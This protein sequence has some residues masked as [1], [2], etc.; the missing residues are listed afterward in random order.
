M[1]RALFNY[2][3][4]TNSLLSFLYSNYFQIGNF[5]EFSLFCSQFYLKIYEILNKYQK[6]RNYLPPLNTTPPH[7]KNIVIYYFLNCIYCVFITNII[8]NY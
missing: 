7:S 3:Y 4:S 2:Q 8:V 5:Y 1:K 6:F